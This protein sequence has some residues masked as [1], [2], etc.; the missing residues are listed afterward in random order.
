MLTE[1]QTNTGQNITPLQ[2]VAQV[3]NDS[4]VSGNTQLVHWYTD[5]QL[6]GFAFRTAQ[7]R[8]LAPGVR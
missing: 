8:A 2:L 7:K 6:V 1:E 5:A 3:M 4:A